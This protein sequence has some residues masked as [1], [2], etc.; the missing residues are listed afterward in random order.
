MTEPSGARLPRGNVVVEV[1]PRSRA[2]SGDMMTVSAS[3][4]SRSLS[5]AL[6][7]RRRSDVSHQ[8]S[9]SSN[10]CPLAV[11]QSRC[12]R[13]SFRRCS[14]TSGTPPARKTRTVVWPTGPLGSASTSRGTVRLMRSQSSNVGRRRPAA[15]A[16]A[17]T[18]NSRL[19]DPPTA[20][21][22]TIAFSM[23]C[24]VRMSLQ[25]IPDCDMCSSARAERTAM[26]SQIGWPDGAS[27][28]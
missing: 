20:A 28:E 6:S 13:P 12:K 1:K 25:R 17:G 24:C 11:R 14:M 8:S 22:T 27:A 21:W 2:L 10:G 4:P 23:A 15:C 26:S 7:S 18:C 5:C 16:I 19:V 3:T 9:T